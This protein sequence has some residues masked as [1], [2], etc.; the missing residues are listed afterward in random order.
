LK[1]IAEEIWPF[2]LVAGIYLLLRATSLNFIN[3]FNL[4]NEQNVFTSSIFTRI[5]TFFHILTIYL[6]LIFLPV[7]LHMERMVSVS[8]SLFSGPVILGAL[9]FFGLFATAIWKIKKYPIL[10]FGILWFFIGLA[11][12]S[13]IAVPINGMLYEHWL[14]F[15]MIGIALI[16]IWLGINM[17]EKFHQI[18]ILLIALLIIS[19]S[20]LSMLTIKRNRQWHDPIV[21]YNQTLAFT[22]GSYRVLNNLGMAY[23]DAKENTKAKETYEKAIAL[24]PKNPIAYHNLGNILR[25]SSGKEQAIANYEK[26]IELDPS[27]FHSYSALIDLYLKE[28]N[29]PKALEYLKKAKELQPGN[30]N[31]ENLIYQLEKLK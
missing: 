2:F 1:K 4:Y 24:D 28:K 18:R 20:T 21:F 5:F 17:F 23:A 9:I 11:P 10:S 7:G 14:Y 3:S 6:G 27:F 30:E 26:A 31:I 15:P 16:I 8:T 25:D 13:N 29:Y 22:P 12:T 19:I